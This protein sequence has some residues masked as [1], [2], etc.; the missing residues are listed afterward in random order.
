MILY[1]PLSE[2][3]IFPPDQE[4]YQNT[5]MTQYNQRPVKAMKMGNG[6]YQIVQLLSTDPQDFMDPD[7]QPGIEFNV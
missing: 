6:N 7:F 2:V 4:E 1:T 5:I 3:D